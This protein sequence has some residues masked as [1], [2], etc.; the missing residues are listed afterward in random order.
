MEA[1][2]E[3]VQYDVQEQALAPLRTCRITHSAPTWLHALTPFRVQRHLFGYQHGA[4]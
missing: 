3:P 4:L 1:L 2:E